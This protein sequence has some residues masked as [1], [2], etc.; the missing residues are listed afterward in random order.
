VSSLVL[1]KKDKNAVVF[2]FAGFCFLW[3]QSPVVSQF[4]SINIC[5]DLRDYTHVTFI[6]VYCLNCPIL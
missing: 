5:H 3:F 6:L 4:K 2:P 1:G